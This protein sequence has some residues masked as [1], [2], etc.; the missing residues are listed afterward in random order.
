MKYYFAPVQ[1]HTDA[2]YRKV[3]SEIYGNNIQYFTPFLR[4]EKD[5]LRK[6][7]LKD[8]QAALESEPSVL[9]QVI[10]RDSNELRTL[11]KILRELGHDKINLNMGCPFPL[12]T[13]RGRGAAALRPECIDAVAEVIAQYPDTEFSIKMR[14]GFK[15]DNE[16]RYLIDVT[17]SIPLDH[18]AVH[19]RIAADQYSG[20]LRL[21]QFR[22]LL[23]I[24]RH[25][26]V[27]NGD[28]NTPEDVADV[29]RQFPSVSGIMIGRGVLGRPSL[30]TE[31]L[32]GEEWN[33][34]RRKETMLKFHD[35]LFDLYRDTLIGGEHQILSKIQPFWEY[36]ECEIGRKAYKALHKASNIAKY[37]TALAMI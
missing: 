7:D 13:A 37:E 33:E 36:A 6:K 28:L 29:L 24:S 27:Y 1:G 26:I 34:S 32:E 8:A 22:E 14:L 5:A 4:L 30:I 31:C 21:Q 9:P 3:H 2:A 18:I 23:E 10:F 17:N 20:E 35:A 19:P 12:Q 15:N 16:W 11:V 25:P